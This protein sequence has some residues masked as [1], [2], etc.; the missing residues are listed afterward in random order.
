MHYQGPMMVL[1]GPGSGKTFVITK[2]VEHLL[3]VHQVPPQN[4]L[5]LTYTKAAA[6]EM[7]GRFLSNFSVSV[8]PVFATFH[9]A[10]FRILQHAY[11][12]SPRQIVTESKKK[13]CLKKIIESR[14]KCNKELLDNVM[15]EIA[16]LKEERINQEEY[17]PTSCIKEQFFLYFQEYEKQLRKH[18][19][20]DFEDILVFC[21]EL[22]KERKDI[23]ENWQKR[24]PYLLVDEFQDINALQYDIVRFLAQPEQNLFVVGDDDQS[25]YR[26]RGAKPEVMFRFDEDYPRTKRV[27]LKQNYRSTC[28]IVESALCLVSHNQQRFVKDI[29]GLD[30]GDPVQVKEFLS[31]KAEAEYISRQIQ[32]EVEKGA[33]YEEFAVLYRINTNPR[34]LVQTLWQANIPFRMKDYCPSMFTHWIA[35]DIFAYVSLALGSQ[36][37]EDILAVMNRPCRY[38]SRDSLPS[39]HVS[40]D[41]WLN[42]YEYRRDLYQNIQQFRKDLKFMQKCTP[43]AGLIYLRKGIGYEEFLEEYTRSQRLKENELMDILEEIT[44]SAKGFSTYEDWMDYVEKQEKILWEEAKANQKNPQSIFLSTIHS[45]KGLEFKQVYLISANEGVIP[46]AKAVLEPE[47]EEERRL[48]YVAMTRAKTQLTITWVKERYGKQSARSRFVSEISALNQTT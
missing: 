12:F 7:K 40:W 2:R 6:M 14:Q 11:G 46:Y 16:F 27:L 29:Q 22:F 45:A 47:I 25:I 24:Y 36:R 9:S 41:I 3:K 23:L 42:F 17:Y 32:Q 5:V 15:A 19:L 34:I 26:F 30:Q 43:Y 31:S 39:S 28:T 4:V 38:L 18:S 8:S 21:Y 44:E 10:F 48:F 35:K 33:K 1:A 20:L 37:R 13:E